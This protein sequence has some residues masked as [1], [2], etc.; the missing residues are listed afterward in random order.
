MAARELGEDEERDPPLGQLVWNPLPAN[1]GAERMAAHGEATGRALSEEGDPAPSDESGADSEEEGED[2]AEMGR[3][4]GGSASGADGAIGSAGNRTRRHPPWEEESPSHASRSQSPVARRN[5]TRGRAA[6]D[7]V[8]ADE[9]GVQPSRRVSSA[10][11]GPSRRQAAATTGWFDRV[12][13]TAAGADEAV[14]SAERL[15]V[16]I[17]QASDRGASP[18]RSVRT[19][20][21]ASCNQ[22]KRADETVG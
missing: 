6:T 3:E 13:G 7:V 9:D 20:C 1:F 16:S 22:P 2:E 12:S 15:V 19:L 14:P 18:G 4:R 8:E 21:V 5:R 10:H 17:L 11:P